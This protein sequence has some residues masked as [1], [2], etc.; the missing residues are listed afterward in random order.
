MP[1]EAGTED[2]DTAFVRAMANEAAAWSEPKAKL[3]LALKENQFLLLAQPIAALHPA[4]GDPF[5]CEILLRL[6]EEEDHLLPPG[7][8]FPIAERYGM[9]EELDRWVVRELITLR[10]D[11][12]DEAGRAALYCV[13]LSQA[14]VRS[15]A[16]A[17]YVQ[18]QLLDRSFDGR[19]LCFEIA[20]GDLV[21]CREDA[22]R[23]IGMLR[24]FGCRFT[25]DAFGSVKGSFAALKGLAFDFVKIDGVL[26]Q[27]M[28]RNPAELARVRAIASVCRKTGVRTIAEFVEDSTTRDTLKRLGIDYVQGFGVARPAPLQPCKPRVPA[29]VP[30]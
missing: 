9:M 18:K 20:E 17:R 7:G 13:N 29:P 6:K 1:G 23:L 14:A 24:P 27:N 19:H 30:A 8:F 26:V 15:H 28:L 16:F 2:E 22:A 3:V 10:H 25:V 4:S 11:A 5:C 21:H 12:E